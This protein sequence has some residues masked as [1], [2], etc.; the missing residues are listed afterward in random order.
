MDIFSFYRSNEVE[1]SYSKFWRLESAEKN[2]IRKILS[3]KKFFKVHLLSYCLMPTHFHFLLHQIDENGI[4]SVMSDLTNSFT[5]YYN[6]VHRRLGPLFL[7]RFKAVP[8]TRD[9][10]LMHV[11]RYI[12]LNPFSSSIISNK[13]ELQTYSFSSYSEYLSNKPSSLVQKEKVMEL[14]SHN[15]SS[16]RKFVLQNADYQEHLEHLKHTYKWR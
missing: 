13:H 15:I 10:Q 3:Y 1:M 6:I 5:R 12:H 7:P 11:S 9:E 4:K 8:V 2:A 16:Y 14:F